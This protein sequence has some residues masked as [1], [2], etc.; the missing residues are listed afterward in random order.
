MTLFEF[1]ICGLPI[2]ISAYLSS[3]EIALFSLSRFQLRALKDLERGPH[4]KIKRLLADQG[5]L[6]ITILVLNE[7]VNIALS[8]FMA[9][10]V[11]TGGVCQAPRR[12]DP[13]RECRLAGR[14]PSR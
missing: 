13:R 3:S 9:P 11:L 4:K 7:M 12:L 8:A 1:I 5:G 2:A 14:V 10:S 6:L